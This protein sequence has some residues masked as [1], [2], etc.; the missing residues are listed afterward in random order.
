MRIG[1]SA[2]QGILD[3]VFG[4]GVF[5]MPPAYVR[6]RNGISFSICRETSIWFALS[7]GGPGVGSPPAKARWKGIRLV[8]AA[9]TVSS[10]PGRIYYTLIKGN[11]RDLRAYH[12]VPYAQ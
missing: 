1:E 3:E 9:S 10:Q 2:Q 6:R 4:V 7:T 12:K 8:S 11:C 5:A